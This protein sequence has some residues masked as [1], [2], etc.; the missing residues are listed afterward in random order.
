MR[1]A[2]PVRVF[3]MCIVFV[4][5]C[6]GDD[7]AATDAS[8]ATD[9]GVDAASSPDASADAS[10]IVDAYGDAPA[11]QT[12][13]DSPDKV[14]LTMRTA[15]GN[16]YVAYVPASYDP[17]VLTPLVIALHGAG[18]T[19]SNYLQ[20]IWKSNADQDGFIVIAPEGTATLGSGF[21]FNISDK[22]L[23]LAAAADIYDCYAIDWRKEILHGFSAG[24]IMAYLIG[25]SQSQLFSGISIS[26]SDLATAE[27]Y[28][29]GPLLPSTW[30]IPF[31]LSHGTQ[32]QNFPIQTTG[33]ASMNIL[34][35]AGHVVY[36]HQFD[37]PHTTT[38]A[39]AQAMYTDLKSSIAP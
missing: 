29:G 38:A 2:K 39:L 11:K 19:A 6:S 15:S 4:E 20:A 32:D 23:I 27:Y 25:L 1:L 3:A 34:E 33:I 22:T 36:W 31:S 35:D 14:G 13:T 12:C 17:T 10:S 21:T 5:G 28:Y 9:V 18:D 24:G 26:S 30:A 7:S 8:S 37:G 16:P